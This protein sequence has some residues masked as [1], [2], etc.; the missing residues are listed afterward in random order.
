MKRSLASIGMVCFAFV[1]APFVARADS[2]VPIGQI[3]LSGQGFVL[4]QSGNSN[5]VDWCPLNSGTPGMPA[6]NVT[7]GDS[8]TGLGF[9]TFSGGSGG[10]SNFGTIPGQ[11]FDIGEQATT[12][13]PYAS[14]AAGTETTVPNFMTIDGHDDLKFTGNMLQLANCTPSAT[15]G[16]VGPLMLSEVGSQTSVSMAI[17]GTLVDTMDGST[18]N[19]EA[20]ITGQFNA[21]MT[22]V[23]SQLESATGAFSDQVS[24]SLVTSWATDAPTPEPGEMGLMVLGLALLGAAGA[25]RSF[26][27]LRRPGNSVLA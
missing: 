22:T 21:P 15:T 12:T 20:V 16:C 5:F 18:A 1:L 4:F 10:F 23:E 17:L 8:N 14:F 27:G 2:D 11:I 26:R 25:S 3:G 19:W 13:T 7:C 24:G 6:G 9:L